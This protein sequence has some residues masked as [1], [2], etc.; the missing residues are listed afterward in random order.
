MKKNTTI[1]VV[2]DDKEDVQIFINAV[3]DI[4]TDIVCYTACDG[5]DALKL[6]STPEIAIPDVIFLDLNMPRMDGRR[7]MEEK[8]KLEY[9]ASVPVIVYSTTRRTKDV[10]EVKKLGASD[11]ITKPTKYKD[12]C[13]EI[14]KVLNQVRT[15]HQ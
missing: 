15:L 11:F 13:N 8:N 14:S 10:D 6:L 1:L 4:D 12:I 2:D 3:Q 9:V 5:I 7:F